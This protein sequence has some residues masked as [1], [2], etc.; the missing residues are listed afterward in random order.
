MFLQPF[1]KLW[2]GLILGILL[3]IWPDSIELW[4]VLFIFV[5]LIRRQ[6]LFLLGIC[7]GII[8][9][10]FSLYLLEPKIP[11]S[12]SKQENIRGVPYERLFN[13]KNTDNDRSGIR[14][15][16]RSFIKGKTSTNYKNLK[17]MRF[18]LL[19]GDSSFIPKEIWQAF[20]Y[21]G[22][23]H[24]LV[25]SGFHLSSLLLLFSFLGRNI[26]LFLTIRSIPLYRLSLSLLIMAFVFICETKISLIRAFFCFSLIWIFSY[27]WPILY[28]YK[29]SERL[30]VIGVLAL[31][32]N[33]FWL[34][35]PSY[36][37]SFGA[38]WALLSS[39]VWQHKGPPLLSSVYIS[40]FIF[41]L[42][43]IFGFSTSFL[44]PVFNIFIIP[45]FFLI[46]IPLIIC[47]L[48]F[49]SI[50]SFSEILLS[51][52][53]NSLSEIFKFMPSLDPLIGLSSGLGI[54]MLLIFFSL[55]ISINLKLRIRL[56]LILAVLVGSLPLNNLFLQNEN[57]GIRIQMLDIGQGDGIL[58]HMQDKKILID[59]GGNIGG[60]RQLRAAVKQSFASEID[61]WVV[62]HFDRDHWGNFKKAS[63]FMMPKQVWVPWLDHSKFGLWIK[64]RNFSSLSEL[65]KQPQRLCSMDFC[66]E[67]FVMN[68]K[69]GHRNVKNNDSIV[70]FLR[71]RGSV[72]VYAVFSG[73]LM[74]TGEK[75]LIQLI[76]KEGFRFK[77]AILKAGHHGSKTSSTEELIKIIKPS[78]ALVTA[79]RHNQYD[80]PHAQVL[81]R[82]KKW[83]AA[84][85][86]VD[87]VGNFEL[88]LDF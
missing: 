88:N 3:A 86:R 36:V 49:P 37:Y 85:W 2:L 24:L 67:G 87:A 38:T 14:Y 78:I 9:L 33:P 59:G 46:L 20:N 82:F 66:L 25:I 10:S 5:V 74:K 29:A 30:A 47:S 34:V 17:G 53:F 23:S 12:A 77:E 42:S 40:C 13:L 22:L 72:D 54:L 63:S 35:S 73:D 32:F 31:I 6:K 70:L 7:I 61:L 26:F 8:R 43:L 15:Q 56:F 76:Q 64:N 21:L 65:I 68:S 69:R 55:F 81:G 28:R 79:G 18:A 39:Q 60:E 4:A 52:F 41:P 50:E 48:L 1:L 71:R 51:L 19:L 58:M 75:K 84:I 11:V 80:F 27:W 44:S 83:G 16:L 57:Q 62:S 45:L